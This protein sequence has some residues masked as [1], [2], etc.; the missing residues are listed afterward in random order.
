MIREKKIP[1]LARSSGTVIAV[2]QIISVNPLGE[3]LAVDP[4]IREKRIV[5]ENFKALVVIFVSVY[6]IQI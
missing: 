5:T 2:A 3:R 4:G 6:M 1:K